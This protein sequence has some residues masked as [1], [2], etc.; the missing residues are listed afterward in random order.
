MPTFEA[1]N[2]G[3]TNVYGACPAS[4]PLGVSLCTLRSTVAEV[5]TLKLRTPVVQPGGTVEFQSGPATA[6]VLLSAPT[7][8]RV[9]RCSAPLELALRDAHGN[10]AMAGA[11]VM[12]HVAQTG[13]GASLFFADATC[14]TTATNPVPFATGALTAMLAFQPNTA[15]TA[16]VTVTGD[17]LGSVS[18]KVAVVSTP[19]GT[20]VDMSRLDAPEVLDPV[21]SVWT[22]L[23]MLVWGTNPLGLSAGGKYNPSLDSWS[24]MS[25]LGAPSLWEPAAVW[26]TITQELLVWG[27]LLNSAISA[28]GG[29]KY[30][31]L[32][33]TWSPMSTL[34]KPGWHG[35]NTLLWTGLFRD[36]CVWGQ[37]SQQQHHSRWCGCALRPRGGFLDSYGGRPLGWE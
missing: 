18:Q 5:K 20:W 24:P 3:D 12:L 25:T 23:E 14:A 27:H 9:G 30:N 16:T 2:T 28:D 17:G 29:A 8:A 6:L 35:G 34:G 26:S 13:P 31:P 21:V 10:S 36:D 4:N 32:T 22:G 1:T 7:C 15:G 19:D 11:N 33:N 37:R